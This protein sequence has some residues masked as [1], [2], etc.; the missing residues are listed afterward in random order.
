MVFVKFIGRK[1]HF[2]RIDSRKIKSGSS[3]SFKLEKSEKAS[4]N[5]KLKLNG[6]HRVQPSSLT[7]SNS[8]SLGVNEE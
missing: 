2:L 6:L 7:I 5:D 8:A 4:V 3:R 1:I